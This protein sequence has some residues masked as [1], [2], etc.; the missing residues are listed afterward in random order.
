[1]Q[2]LK[3]KFVYLAMLFIALILS[4]SC[5]K[6]TDLLADYIT[7]DYQEAR[8]GA[9]IFIN[10]VYQFSGD[11]MVLDVLA[12]DSISDPDNVKIIDTSTPKNGT[13]I[14]NDDKTLTYLPNEEKEEAL[15]Q[16]ENITENN[17]NPIESSDDTEKNSSDEDTFTYTVEIDDNG[18]KVT[19]E[20]T[21]KI[22]MDMGEL[23][24]FPGAEGFGKHTTG[25][26]GGY[27]YAVTNLNDFGKGSLRYGVE[28]ISGNRT[29]IFNVSGY[30]NLTKPLKIR[31]GFGNIT[32]AGQSAPNQGITL[33]GSSFWVQDSNV[34]IRYIRIR[35]GKDW[36]TTTNT[37]LDENYE[38]DD[39]LRIIA[40]SGQHLS[41][42]IIDHCSLSWGR[43]EILDISSS[44]SGSI[45]NVTI[46]NCIISE[47]LDKGYG[48]LVSNNVSNLTFYKNVLAHNK[49]RN[50]LFNNY[51]DGVEFIN[52]IIYNFSRGT[53]LFYGV[54]G[55]LI[56]N[57]YKTNSTSNRKLETVRLESSEK[58]KDNTGLYIFDNYEN[59]NDITISSKGS[60]NLIT[61]ISSN[62]FFNSKTPNIPS[63]QVLDNVLPTVGAYLFQDAIDKRII[64]EIINGNGKR[65][66]HENQVGGYPSL[67]S[68]SRPEK[69]DS[70]LD[71]I[72][73][74]WEYSNNLEPLNSDDGSSDQNNDGFTNLE[75]YLYSLEISN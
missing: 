73:D 53:I 72:P 67:Q 9:N 24:A 10:D 16:S 11:T 45:S 26:R 27:V 52:N 56:G 41:N 59:S 25:G 49:E 14:I 50:I 61:H 2:N 44:K 4:I 13:V 66:T 30:I 23:R 64:T 42:I 8:L 55:D 70:D 40:Y 65:I 15:A 20:A 48:V 63:G 22:V 17:Q 46:Q 5:S 62:R 74:Q 68:I 18:K 19:Q 32:I 12:N 6:D 7:Q 60:N 31:K 51:V 71:G 29:I 75:D 43:D 35:P 34:I 37:A 1:M 57:V 69:F 54:K 36:T 28:T 33:K 58:A 21:V 47:N 39:V 3:I 38:P